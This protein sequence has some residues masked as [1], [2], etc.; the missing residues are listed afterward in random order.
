VNA[1][2]WR[3]LREDDDEARPIAVHRRTERPWLAAGLFL[4]IL[5]ARRKRT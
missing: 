5:W 3:G 1:C 2:P 4:G